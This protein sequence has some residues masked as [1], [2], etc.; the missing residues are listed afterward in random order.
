MGIHCYSIMHH[1]PP[2]PLSVSYRESLDTEDL[3]VILAEMVPV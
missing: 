3:T 1:H 2:L